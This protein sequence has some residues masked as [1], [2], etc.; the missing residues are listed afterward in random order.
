VNMKLGLQLSN[1][2]S[3]RPHEYLVRFFLGGLT[4]VVT[5]LIAHRFGPQAGGLF[6]AFPAIF[7]ASATLIEKH[8][9]E[10]KRKRGL[11]GRGRGRSAAALDA[12]G[13]SLGSVGLIAFALSAW[14]LLLRYGASFAICFSTASWLTTSLLALA[15]RRAI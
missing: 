6:L 13:A 10:K 14:F 9:M 5:G 1:L 15:V 11:D 2:R 12:L 4:T 8:E 7:P 3:V